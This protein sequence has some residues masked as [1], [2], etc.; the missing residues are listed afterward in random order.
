MVLFGLIGT[1]WASRVYLSAPP[2]VKFSDALLI[3][4]LIVAPLIAG[5]VGGTLVES[6]RLIGG[7]VTAFVLPIALKLLLMQL[8]N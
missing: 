5:A 7:I 6:A 2:D 8:G 3:G 1:L 4:E